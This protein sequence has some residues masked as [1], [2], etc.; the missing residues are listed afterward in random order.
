VK[1]ALSDFKVVVWATDDL[2]PVSSAVSSRALAIGAE[3]AAAGAEVSFTARPDFDPARAHE[4]YQTLL[5]SA[6]TSGMDAEAVARMQRRADMIISPLGSAPWQSMGSSAGILNNCFGLGLRLMPI[7]PVPF[8]QPAW[9]MM[10][11]PL[12]FRP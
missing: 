7:Y 11:Y 4:N 9:R 5:N 10:D 6:M 3:L 2:A 1:Q 12:G 8:F